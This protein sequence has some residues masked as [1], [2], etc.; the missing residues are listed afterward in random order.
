MSYDTFFHFSR[1]TVI[2][3]YILSFYEEVGARDLET[4]ESESEV[5]CTGS[6]ALPNT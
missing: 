4:E 6:T 1:F 2:I 3:Y 5:L